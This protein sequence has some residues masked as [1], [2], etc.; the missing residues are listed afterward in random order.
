M[1]KNE[2]KEDGESL[3]FIWTTVSDEA[4]IEHTTCLNSNHKP[5]DYQHGCYSKKPPIHYVQFNRRFI[6]KD[7]L[8][9][10][11]YV[12]QRKNETAYYFIAPE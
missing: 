4:S 12:K 7:I 8:P 2:L 1:Q 10:E 6:E 9:R 5:T 3:P 11:L